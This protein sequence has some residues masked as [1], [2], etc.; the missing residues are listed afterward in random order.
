MMTDQRRR[1]GGSYASR[2]FWNR[3]LRLTLQWGFRLLYHEGAWSYDL[4]AAAVSRGYWQ[5]WIEAVLP[6]LGAG[7]TLEVGSG[8]GYLQRA[9]ALQ[10]CSHIGVDRS[11]QMLHWGYRKVAAAGAVPCLALGD[12]HHLPVARASCANVVATFPAPFILEPAVITELAAC[13]LPTGQIL[14]VDDGVVPRARCGASTCR[15]H[16]QSA[17]AAPV[18]PRNALFRTAGLHVTEERLSVG[19]SHVWLLRASRI[20]RT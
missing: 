9:L 7:T 17:V 16:D 20:A 3:L 15:R 8:T 13:L 18:V 14:V 19:R 5:H 4:V 6:T 11:R 2:L 1:R 12:V 10:G